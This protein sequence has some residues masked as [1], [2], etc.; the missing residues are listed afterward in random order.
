MA[1]YSRQRATI[2]GRMTRIEK[3]ISDFDSLKEQTVQHVWERINGINR[4][5]E[6]FDAVQIN[7]ENE[8]CSNTYEE[9]NKRPGFESRYFDAVAKLGLIVEKLEAAQNS[10]IP[11]APPYQD[12][13]NQSAAVVQWYVEPQFRLPPLELP[14]FHGDVMDCPFLRDSFVALIHNNGQ[15]SDVQKQFYLKSCLKGEAV[16]MVDTLDNTAASYAAAWEILS[17]RYDN[18]RINIY[19][20]VQNLFH[21]PQIT[22]ESS[23][24]L[25]KLLTDFQPNVCVLKQLAQPTRYWGTLL[26]YLLSSKL[27]HITRRDWANRIKPS[28]VPVIGQLVEFVLVRCQALEILAV[29][30]RNPSRPKYNAVINIV[31]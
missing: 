16:Y 2:F 21:L 6:D 17:S 15:L 11:S 31:T 19:K 26:H 9:D 20:H 8:D 29:E 5:W 7:I 23:K 1:E 27:D 4:L 30:K 3:C 28:E 13:H 24:S 25:R 10:V 18:K 22:E 14:R 12:E